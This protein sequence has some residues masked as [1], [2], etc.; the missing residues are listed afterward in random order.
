M[1][2][3]VLPFQAE[4]R[5]EGDKTVLLLMGEINGWPTRQ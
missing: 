2:T 1:N 3:Q 4:V 5:E